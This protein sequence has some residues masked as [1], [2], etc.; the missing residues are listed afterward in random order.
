MRA[1]AYVNGRW[2]CDSLAKKV[3]DA[4]LRCESVC[5]TPEIITIAK[6]CLNISVPADMKLITAES[7]NTEIFV[8]F[9]R[10]SLS[11]GKRLPQA[12]SDIR[13][14][15]NRSVR[16]CTTSLDPA[17]LAPLLYVMQN[18]AMV[19][20]AGYIAQTHLKAIADTGGRLVVAHDV[21]DSVGRLDSYFPDA[22]FFTDRG[23][24]EKFC[25]ERMASDDPLHWLTVCT[26]NHTHAGYMEYGM[27]LGVD[28]ICEKPAALHAADIDR[29][30]GME[31]ETGR[32]VYTILQLRLHDAIARLR[33]NISSC[34]PNRTWDV[35]LTYIASRGRWYHTSWKGDIGKSGG[36]AMNIGVHFYDMLQWVFGQL[37][38]NVVH[39]KSFDRVAGYME[40]DRARVRYFLS[41]NSDTL[42]AEAVS[43]GKRTFRALDIDGRRFDFSD[44]FAGLHTRSYADILT[45]NGF[46]IS[47]ARPGVAIADMVMNTA[48]VGLK[49][50]YHPFAA[51]PQGGHPLGQYCHK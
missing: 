2:F 22:W 11:L 21:F 12:R 40:F 19:G 44:G 32:R 39:V 43:E 33:D 26:P 34:D 7:V 46:G 25:N 10:Y 45:G 17:I 8:N 30:I 20:A 42:P 28:V 24:F 50:D 9:V 36:V 6:Q 27:R 35:D 47:E 29:M 51:L 41:I 3:E 38:R 18:F 1:Q 49:G 31:S 48:P 14:F 4:I 37:R 15:I 13:P 16:L 23:I 5:L